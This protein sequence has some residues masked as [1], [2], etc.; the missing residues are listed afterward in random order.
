[1]LLVADE[2]FRT[3]RCWPLVPS[4]DDLE[5][6]ALVV[7]GGEIL[8]HHAVHRDGGLL[9]KLQRNILLT[10]DGIDVRRDGRGHDVHARHGGGV[11]RLDGRLR[12][13]V[14]RGMLMTST[15]GGNG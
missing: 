5:V 12:T 8:E 15:P 9:Q 4:G 13:R 14:M 6:E 10:G 2:T 7:I 3:P 1:M 11:G